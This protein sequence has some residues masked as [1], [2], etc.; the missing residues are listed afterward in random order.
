[1]VAAVVVPAGL[2]WWTGPDTLGLWTLFPGCRAVLS[3]CGGLLIL[4]GLLLIAATI[5]LFAVAGRGTLA[6]WDPPRRLVVRG[7]YRHVRNPM[8]LGVFCLLLGEALIGA[9]LWLLGWAGVF[10]AANAL[11]FPLVEEPQLRKRFG[12]PYNEYCR[13]VPR[14]RPRI[15]PWSPAC[16]DD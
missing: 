10:L 3:G 5:R 9:S 6:P 1:M 12:P 15:R 13:H 8:I 7:V 14:W 2:L 4:G 16:R 11:Y